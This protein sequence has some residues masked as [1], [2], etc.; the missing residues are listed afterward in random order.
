MALEARARCRRSGTGFPDR[1][2]FWY[3]NGSRR[4]L[5]SLGIQAVFVDRR[6]GLVNRE[7]ARREVVRGA[8]P[9]PADVLLSA[10]QDEIRCTGPRAGSR[11]A[12]AAGERYRR[13]SRVAAAFLCACT[14]RGIQVRRRFRRP[15]ATIVTV[16]ER[17][18]AVVAG[19]P[20]PPGVT[21]SPLDALRV[22]AGYQVR[23]DAP[24][25]LCSLPPSTCSRPWPGCN[26]K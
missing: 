5:L 23:I 26:A 7:R 14:R 22:N 17:S 12:H 21:G 25:V 9:C 2:K 15:V 13:A 20:P 11:R 10:H 1:L 4:T 8:P 18:V 16:V 19:Q 3:P 24:G 6:S